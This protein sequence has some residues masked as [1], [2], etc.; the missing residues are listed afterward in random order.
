MAS[1]TLRL[2][3]T[4]ADMKA[5]EDLQMIIW[6]GS[7]MDVVPDHL[8]ITLAHNG[9]PVI[10][11]HELDD[12]DQETQL[13]GVVFGFPGID[14]TSADLPFKF[15]S[16][17]MGVHPKFEGAGIGF[18]LKRAQW[19]MARQ[20]G[21][22]RITW[23]YDPLLSRNAHL[24]IAKLGTV[25]NTYKREIYGEMRDG[26]NVG[27]LSDRFQVDWWLTTPRVE[28]R[29][30]NQP[31]SRLNLQQYL[32]GGVAII[33]PGVYTPEGNLSPQSEAAQIPDRSNLLLVE[34]PSYIQVLKGAA[35]D[36]ALAWRLQTRQIFEALFSAGYLVTDFVYQPGPQPRSYYL[37]SYGESTF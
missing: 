29:L 27:F 21:Y 37:L 14:E 32:E 5:A 35:P 26:L 36:L 16:H 30:G 3:N 31:A 1:W 23:T 34:I 33:N 6:P 17:Q 8:L 11:A 10:G 28:K 15:C 20:Q 12:K 19:Q 13:I 25:C 7:P 2:L 24:N 9:S 22:A 18:A 4:P